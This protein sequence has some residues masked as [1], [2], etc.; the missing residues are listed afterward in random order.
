M[1][2]YPGKGINLIEF[3]FPNGWSDDFYVDV[4]EYLKEFRLKHFDDIEPFTWKWINND[5]KDEIPKL[6]I[7]PI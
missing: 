1:V 5:R 3:E 4:E 6:I 2:G 7:K